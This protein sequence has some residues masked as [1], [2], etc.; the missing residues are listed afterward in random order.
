MEVFN[1]G[2]MS[3]YDAAGWMNE[4][5]DMHPKQ[6]SEGHPIR[7]RPGLSDEI[8]YTPP[9][10]VP[11]ETAS[12]TFCSGL[13]MF[14]GLTDSEA[15]IILTFV[16]LVVLFIANLYQQI[17]ALRDSVIYMMGVNKL[18]ANAGEP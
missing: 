12:E 14:N 6:T 16:I 18:R 1:Y 4:S 9:R 8:P 3:N 10:E 5:Y 15:L 13:P 7:D 11:S 2:D 17:G